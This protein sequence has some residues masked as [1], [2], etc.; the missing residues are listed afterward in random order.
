M[1]TEP[2]TEN[3]KPRLSPGLIARAKDAV[4]KL[5]RKYANEQNITN[6]LEVC[7]AYALDVWRKAAEENPRTGAAQLEGIEIQ[8]SEAAIE[9]YFRRKLKGK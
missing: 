9:K 1:A 8:G 3:Q 5:K 6:S 7:A 2:K 4:E